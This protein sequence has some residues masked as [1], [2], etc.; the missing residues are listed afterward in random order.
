MYHVATWCYI[1]AL[2]PSQLSI[3]MGSVYPPDFDIM[4]LQWHK[5]YL[6]IF[7]NFIQRELLLNFSRFIILFNITFVVLPTCSLNHSPIWNKIVF[8]F[9][10]KTKVSFVSCIHH[11]R[12]K[13]TLLEF[14]M[15][16]LSGDG[17]AHLRLNSWIVAPKLNDLLGDLTQSINIK[18]FGR[19]KINNEIQILY[20]FPR[21]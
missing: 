10:E 12:I 7:F 13:S 5:L 1:H 6:S 2:V 16:F 15:T 8:I 4:V 21:K 17:W 11:F 14:N 18:T 9:Q 3:N 20:G 19:W